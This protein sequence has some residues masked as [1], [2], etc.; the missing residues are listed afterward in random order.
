MGGVWWGT[1]TLGRRWSCRPCL[2]LKLTD[3]RKWP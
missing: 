3:A 1:C 2:R